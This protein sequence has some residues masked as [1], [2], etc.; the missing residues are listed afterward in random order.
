MFVFGSQN[1]S[2]VPAQNEP[3]NVFLWTCNGCCVCIYMVLKIIGFPIWPFRF[4]KGACEHP[5]HPLCSFSGSALMPTSYHYSTAYAALHQ[6]NGLEEV[7]K[8]FGRHLEWG[9]VSGWSWF[10]NKTMLDGTAQFI[11]FGRISIQNVYFVFCL[12][13]F[14][15]VAKTHCSILRSLFHNFHFFT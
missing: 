9:L 3:L 6:Q 2:T 7:R 5:L 13:C 10:L 14:L 15:T 4:Q 1:V 11:L 12:L 8:D